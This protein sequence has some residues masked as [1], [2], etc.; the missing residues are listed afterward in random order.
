MGFNTSVIIRNDS[1]SFIEQDAEFGKRLSQTISSMVEGSIPIDVPAF[2][3]R[4][5]HV[6]AA[7]VVETHHADG[8]SLVAFGQ[9]DATNL[10]VFFPYGSESFD[11]RMLKALADKLG[12][13]VAK[14]PAQVFRSR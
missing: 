5:C 3:N 4:G 10:G 13:R 14:K 7:T 8:T 2:I 1:L 9:N 11:V 12:Y 6:N